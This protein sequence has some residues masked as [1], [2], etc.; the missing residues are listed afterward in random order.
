M[1]PRTVLI[2]S[3]DAEFS[4]QVVARWQSERAVP[5]F[6]VLGGDPKQGLDYASFDLTIVGPI[7]PDAGA[8]LL[9]AIDPGRKA[10]I[11][12]ADV[13]LPDSLGSQFP[14]VLV[15]RRHEG[16]PDTLL[17]LALEVLRRVDA[18]NRAQRAEHVNALLKCHATL[19]Q[20]IIEMRHTINN[21]LTSVLGNAE[22]LLLEPGTFS[23]GVRSQI[24]T[25]RNMALRMHEILQRFSSL[26]KE[27]MFVEKQA[28]KEQRTQIQAAAVGQ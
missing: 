15:L 19:G 27:M 10:V 14:R 18:V 11:L 23:A 12:F 4:R 22:L 24:D 25:I 5:A 2:L 20:Y 9:R 26:E 28:A 16:W 21:A 6:T 3:D 8:P 7:R 1:D 17:L 13:A